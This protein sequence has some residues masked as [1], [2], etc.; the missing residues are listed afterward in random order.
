MAS[1]HSDWIHL[2]RVSYGW[3]IQRGYTDHA[4]NICLQ[5]LGISTLGVQQ[6]HDGQTI[7]NPADRQALTEAVARVASVS[8]R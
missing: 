7:T 8:S 6:I 4:V 1:A 5:T 2:E 3:Q